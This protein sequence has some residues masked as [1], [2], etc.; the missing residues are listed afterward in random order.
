M[1]QLNDGLLFHEI[2][3]QTLKPRNELQRL[4]L[5]MRHRDEHKAVFLPLLQLETIQTNRSHVCKSVYAKH[6]L[7][8]CD[9]LYHK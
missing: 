7:G 6:S 2:I 9:L 1:A 8:Y 4:D 3:H 5:V